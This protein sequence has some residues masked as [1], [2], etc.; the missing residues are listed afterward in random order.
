MSVVLTR[1]AEARADERISWSPAILQKMAARALEFGRPPAEFSGRFRRYLDG[2]AH[3]HG[4]RLRVYGQHPY[5][6]G[7]EDALVTVFPLPSE[8]HKYL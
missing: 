2:K 3:A 7:T 8:F 1:H 6:F 4:T 5:C